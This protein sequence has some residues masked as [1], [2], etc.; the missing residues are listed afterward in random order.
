MLL[1]PH[2]CSIDIDECRLETDQCAQNCH[3]NVG[4]YTC[5]CNVGYT[6]NSD[7]R[8]CD[9]KNNLHIIIIVII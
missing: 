5:S 8:H 2:A 3:N 9:G 6:L 7:G 4:S 1:L